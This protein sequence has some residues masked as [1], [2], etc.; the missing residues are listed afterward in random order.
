[1][2]QTRFQHNDRTGVDDYRFY[3]THQQTLGQKTRL[4]AL[5]NFT[6]SKQ[7]NQDPLSGQPFADRVNRFLNSNLQLSHYAD[8]I[9]LS[10]VVDR[11][12]DLDANDALLVPDFIGLLPKVGAP[13]DRPSLT[14]SEPSLSISLPTRALGSYPSLKDHALGKALGST[15]LALSG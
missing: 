8:S 2:I 11:Q 6:S 10:A 7:F 15:Y 14:V 12:Q 1:Q 4:S 3:G 5:G 13:A 9:S